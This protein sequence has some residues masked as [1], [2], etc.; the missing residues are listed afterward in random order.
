VVEAALD[1]GASV[2]S[3]YIAAE[4]RDDKAVAALADRALAAGARVFDLGPGIMAR[5]ADTV[6][7]QPVCAVVSEPDTTLGTLLESG[8]AGERLV[9][10]CVDVRDPG[11]LGSLIRSGAAAAVHGVVCVAGTVDPY[12]PKTVRATAGAIFTLPVAV[13]R[14]VDTALAALAG[15]GFR[16]VATTSGGGE[17]YSVADLSGDVALVLGNEAAGLDEGLVGRCSSAVHVPMSPQ[18]ES[19][20]VAMT[21]TV[22]AFEVARRR[23]AHAGGEGASGPSLGSAATS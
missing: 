15:A 13:E 22:L 7:P 19:L 6:S 8:D 3:L 9:L 17:D 21:A 1:A 16:L 4:G 10:V 2:E 11:N 5:T 23:R 14:S 20:N 12:N 18:A